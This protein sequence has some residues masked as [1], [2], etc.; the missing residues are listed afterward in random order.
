MSVV[1]DTSVWIDFFRGKTVRL[2]AEALRDGT[3]VIPP[4]VVAE[5]VSGAGRP[6]DRR[7]IGELLHEMP[8]HETSLEHWI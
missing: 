5:L 8:V 1:V 4:I 6:R 7:A 2:L 3:V